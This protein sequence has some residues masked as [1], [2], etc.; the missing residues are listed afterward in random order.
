MADKIKLVIAFLIVAGAVAGFYY[1][2]EQATLVRVLA[3]LAAF[4]LS[5]ALAYQTNLGRSTWAFAQESQVE[6]RK[7]VWPTKEE[8]LK[9]TGL[10]IVMVIIIALILWGLDAILIWAVRHLTG[11]G[12]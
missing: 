6:V 3:T 4:G 7:V 1:F 12:A 8:A 2:D 5:V 11:Q 9:T 10:V